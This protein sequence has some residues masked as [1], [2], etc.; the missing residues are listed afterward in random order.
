VWKALSKEPLRE[1]EQIDLSL[2]THSALDDIVRGTG[3]KEHFVALMTASSLA[4]LLASYGY[5]QEFADV[6]L[7]AQAVLFQ[8]G[9]LEALGNGYSLDSEGIDA[10]RDLLVLQ[11][12]QNKLASRAE[13]INAIMKV[14]DEIRRNSKQIGDTRCTGA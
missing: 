7:K 2:V 12:A 4:G 13:V 10:I 3:S 9:Q 5:G 1:A 11:T 6:I 14:N 8:C